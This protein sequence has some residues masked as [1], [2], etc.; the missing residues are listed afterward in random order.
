MIPDTVMAAGSEPIDSAMRHIGSAAITQGPDGAF[1]VTVPPVETGGARM[2]I[3][4][5]GR[6]YPF[7]T[8]FRYARPKDTEAPRTFSNTEF[9]PEPPG[10]RVGPW[11]GWRGIPPLPEA[12]LE[13]WGKKFRITMT[14]WGDELTT[15]FIRGAAVLD[16]CPG[17]IMNCTCNDVRLRPVRADVYACTVPEAHA[18]PV[19]LLENLTG[20]HPRL[21]ITPR[22]IPS[23]AGRAAG[24]HHA[25]WKRVTDL[26]A[27]RPEPWQI[28]PESKVMPGPERLRG[29]DRALLSA[30]ASI[31]EPTAARQEAAKAALLAFAGETQSPG[32]EP[33]SIDT[34]AGESLFILCVCLDWTYGLWTP[35]EREGLSRWI[36]RAADICWS[37]LGY[38]RRDYA[39]AHY[40][41]CALKLLAFSFLA[42]ETH[43]RAREWAAHCR[44]VLDEV[45][46]MLPPDGFYPHGINLW[47]YEYGFLLRWLELFRVC[48]GVDLWKGNDHWRNASAFRRAAASPDLRYGSTFGDAQHLVG[49]DSWCHYLI[50]SRTGSPEARRLGDMLLDVPPDGIDFRSI[51]P[52]RR[53]YELLYYDSPAV[54]DIPESPVSLFADGGQVFARGSGTLFTFRAG[55]PLGIRRYVAGEPGGYG[56]A[57]PGNGSFL[58]CAAGGPLASWPGPVYRRDTSLHN[59]IT[60]DGQGQIGDSTVWLPDFFPPDALCPLPRINTEGGRVNISASLAPS[61]LPHLRV[62]TCLRNL[63]VEPGRWI[64]GVDTVICAAP[65]LLQWNI[66]APHLRVTGHSGAKIGADLGNTVSRCRLIMFDPIEAVVETGHAALVPAYPHD[67]RSMTALRI[68]Y[69][70]TRTRFVWCILLDGNEREPQFDGETCSLRFQDGTVITE[71]ERGWAIVG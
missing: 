32:Y 47:I 52:R 20:T 48:S 3:L 59:T 70:G 30:L 16:S 39:Q 60:V 14:P 2:L 25:L 22:E 23:L 65:H 46:R 44:G 34:Q 53:V 33:F 15:G 5:D 26:I 51:P 43:P 62:L 64:A 40:L 57:D 29:D 6:T 66:H 61:Y 63:C 7:E 71:T 55:P 21:L 18:H 28:T 41:G 13:G 37:H 31:V 38:E 12:A 69:R 68:T 24:S 4:F 19:S 11:P 56:H 1:A 8:H 58:I 35:E 27:S 9:A 49:G 42:W 17:G 36:A 67:G 10:L 50:A 45:I 54:P